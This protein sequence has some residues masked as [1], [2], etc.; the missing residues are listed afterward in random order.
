MI[1]EFFVKIV[2]ELGAT[3]LLVLGLYYILFK[4]MRDIAFHVKVINDEL[5]QIAKLYKEEMQT[6]KRDN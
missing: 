5:G 2:E 3:G 1:H 4:P 6:K